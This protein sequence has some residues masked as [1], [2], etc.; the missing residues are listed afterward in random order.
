MRQAASTMTGADSDSRSPS[1]DSAY[2]A[3][4]S[5][6]HRSSQQPMS[7]CAAANRCATSSSA[8]AA[9]DRS[10]S[11]S[12]SGEKRSLYGVRSSPSRALDCHS[13]SPS[14]PWAEPARPV[15][16]A[17]WARFAPG[18]GLLRP[19]HYIAVRWCNLE[20]GKNR[21]FGPISPLS[22]GVGGLGV[23]PYMGGAGVEIVACFS[24]NATYFGCPPRLWS[25]FWA[26]GGGGK[27]TGGSVSLGIRGMGLVPPAIGP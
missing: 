17:V 8:S 1:L 26:G 21:V 18:F 12:D 6:C 2:Y 19:A 15:I 25:P 4:R 3:T 16:Q 20:R 22:Q 13:P 27:T 7:K 23:C 5:Q 9:H 10:I 11:K 14:L 24:K